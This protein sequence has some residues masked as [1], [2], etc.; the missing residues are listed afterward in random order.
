MAGDSG[1]SASRRLPKFAG[2]DGMGIF[3]DER[4][5]ADKLE[6]VGLPKWVMNM[7]VLAINDFLEPL[8]EPTLES[9]QGRWRLR[10]R[11]LDRWT[12]HRWLFNDYTDEFNF[13]AVCAVLGIDCRNARHRILMLR[14]VGFSVPRTGRRKRRTPCDTITPGQSGPESGEES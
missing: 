10:E 6:Q 7:T 9:K 4:G 11:D 12:A 13:A 8:P 3:P 1:D 14:S 2:L 5:W